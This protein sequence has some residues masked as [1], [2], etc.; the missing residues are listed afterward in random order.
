MKHALRLIAVLAGGLPLAACATAAAMP[1]PAP[2]P[3]AAVSAGTGTAV[4]APAARDTGRAGTSAADVRF[5]QGMI[6]HH[7]QALQMVA[8]LPSRTS[9]QDLRLLAERIRVSQE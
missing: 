4:A 2:A 3:A 5:M 6:G 9:R 8:L 7:S 1:W